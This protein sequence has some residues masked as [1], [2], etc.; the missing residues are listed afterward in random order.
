MSRNDAADTTRN[1]AATARKAVLTELYR[2]GVAAEVVR[3]SPRRDVIMARA[4]GGRAICIEVR[5]KQIATW[6]LVHGIPPGEG[7]LVLVDLAESAKQPAPEFYVLSADDWRTI[8]VR[9]IELFNQAH[10]EAQAYLQQ[11]YCPYFPQ[12]R[13]DGSPVKGCTV[14]I[15]DVETHRDAWQK[16]IEACRRCATRWRMSGGEKGPVA[17]SQARSCVPSVGPMRT[18][19]KEGNVTS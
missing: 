1:T 9:H 19:R 15:T 16:I 13:E 4:E 7:F 5:Y 11:E 10:S 17:R 3:L 12:N 14:R 8:A 6:T 2:L 18:D